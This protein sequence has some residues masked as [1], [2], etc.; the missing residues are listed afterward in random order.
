MII[1]SQSILKWKS[2]CGACLLQLCGRTEVLKNN[3]PRRCEGWRNKRLGIF[4][5]CRLF[6]SLHYQTYKKKIGFEKVIEMMDDMGAVLKMNGRMM[7]IRRKKAV[8]HTLSDAVE[9]SH[10]GRATLKEEIAAPIFSFPGTKKAPFFTG[11][12]F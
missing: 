4:K 10:P 5:K 12:E 9:S 7:I 1:K 3:Q 6:S 8:T 2:C 11:A